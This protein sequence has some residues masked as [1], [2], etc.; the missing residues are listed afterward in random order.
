MKCLL[1][2]RSKVGHRF[3]LD[4]EIAIFQKKLSH[5][6]RVNARE[7]P[8]R[9]DNATSY[10]LI[11]SELLLQRT[12]A[13]TV[14]LYWPKFINIFSDWDTLANTSEKKICKILQ[15]LGLSRQRAP[16]IKALAVEICTEKGRFPQTQ[17]DILL[18]PGVGQY[19]ANAILLFVHD[20]PAPLL[21]VNMAR[22]L[23]RYFGSRKLVDIRFDPYLQ[24]LS[25]MIVTN[26]DPRMIN[27]AILDLGALVCKSANPICNQCPLKS[28][29]RHFH[30]SG[31]SLRQRK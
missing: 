12:R 26:N 14:E 24:S 9:N 20:V 4:R 1:N 21:D 13:E 22:V 28:N 19:I 25:K 6:W 15:P 30:R 18:L 3:V 8:W 10:H 17:E 7:F 11:V 27:W 2:K 5:W 16:R 29:C 31:R 23:E